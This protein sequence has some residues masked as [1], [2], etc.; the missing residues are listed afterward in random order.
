M[1]A[2]TLGPIDI[3]VN[4][5]Q[6]ST[7]PLNAAIDT[8]TATA[9]SQRGAFPMS[10]EEYRIF[11]EQLPGSA[12][13]S[14]ETA[15]N[16]AI[17]KVPNVSRWLVDNNRSPNLT[18]DGVPG[19][20]VET[21]VEGGTDSD[22]MLALYNSLPI[23]VA[24]FGDVFVTDPSGKIQRFSRPIVVDCRVFVLWENSGSQNVLDAETRAFVKAQI[25]QAVVD[26]ISPATGL[27]YNIGR[28]LVPDELYTVVAPI[29]PQGAIKT[30]EILASRVSDPPV[31]TPTEMGNKERVRV[32]IGNSLVVIN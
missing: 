28:D 27:G 19:W 2:E 14:I 11:A 31:E 9:D 20:E 29:I 10:D 3:A 26:H 23:T 8:I 17:S 15:V 21:I 25:E 13:V 1:T 7:A 5:T 18:V 4:E 12:T 6:W 32:Q 30:L 22:I 24:S 16:A